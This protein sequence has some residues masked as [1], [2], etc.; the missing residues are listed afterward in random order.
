[1]NKG[2]TKKRGRPATGRDPTITI[3]LPADLIRYIDGRAHR[4]VTSR[5]D[6]IRLLIEESELG[7][8]PGFKK[9]RTA[10]HE[11]GH[12]VIARLLDVTIYKATIR[13]Q[14]GRYYKVADGSIRQS[15]GSEGHV[16]FNPNIPAYFSRPDIVDIM[17]SMA[18]RITEELLVGYSPNGGDGSDNAAIDKTVRRSNINPAELRKAR[19]QV[20]DK[21]WEYAESI[22][23]VAAHLV[24]S[25]TMNARQIDRI[26]A[27]SPRRDRPV[28][29]LCCNWGVA[30]NK[31]VKLLL[32]A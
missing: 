14:A 23:R 7:L 21:I 10:Y 9:S 32:P 19:K 1:M 27:G 6:M 15:S 13:Y 24:K 3:R 28:K 18:G 2:K 31:T 30:H 4:A 8:P 29:C 22:K 11:A 25:E 20:H 5:S 16:T 12:A 17:I 26:I